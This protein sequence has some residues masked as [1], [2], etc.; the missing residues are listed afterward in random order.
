MLKRWIPRAALAGALLV[1]GASFAADG[2]LDP[3]F[4]DGGV[5]YLSIDGIEGHELRTSEVIALPDGKLLFGGSRNLL[6]NGNPD[7]HMR[8]SLERMNADGTPDASFGDDPSN[9]GI[10]VLPPIGNTG[11]QRIEG[12]RRLGDGT[13]VVAGSSF[14]FGP[15]TGFVMKLDADGH[16]LPTFGTDGLV[17]L[18]GYYFHA[19]EVD[20]DGNIVVAGEQVASGQS[21]GYVGRLLPDGTVDASF[22]A[23]GSVLLEPPVAGD[24]TYLNTLAMDDRGAIVVGGFYED[25]VNFTS[26]FSVARLDAS[27]QL[28]TSFDGDGWRVFR[29]PGDASTF[30]GVDRL[31]LT[32]NGGIVIAAHHDDGMGGTGIVLGRLDASGADDTGFGTAG[33]QSYDVAPDAWNRYPSAL[34]RQ[35]DGKLLVGVTYAGEGRQDFIALRTSADGALDASFGNGGMVD[36]DLAPQGVYS[37]LT[38]MTLQDGKPILAGGAKRDPASW[39]VDVAAVRLQNGPAGDDTVFRDGF[40][41]APAEPVVSTYDDLAENFLGTSTVYNG[42]TYHDANGIGGVFPDGSTFTPDDVGDQFIIEDAAIFYLDFPDY[43]S[44]PNVMTFGT[45]YINGDNFSVGAL[46]RATMDLDTPASAVSVDLAFYENG[47]WG[48]IVLH[49]DAYQGGSVVGS[50]SLTISDLGGRDNMTTA[51]FSISGVT[52]DSL[53]LYATY[54]DQPSAPRVM[55]DDLTLTPASGG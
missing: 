19:L 35:A 30:N 17:T 48:G 15:L 53:K 24:N 52:F 55:I 31:L 47:P 43:G 11:M 13:I 45:S 26:E 39:L 1:T 23:G 28:D 10:V 4:G 9:P 54:G 51:T 7:P 12:M 6:I 34:L 41:G 40:D 29:V 20:A 44:S 22:G 16:P 2:D 50:D 38:A 14:A 18:Q 36:F 25:S 32:P 46:V 37:D 5:A 33:Y 42:V 8:P 27:G 3:T 21:R 49:L